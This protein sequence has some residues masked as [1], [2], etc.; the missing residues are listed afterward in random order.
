MN[1]TT[2]P[3][4]IT[5]FQDTDRTWQKSDE[6][7][8]K[9]H[10]AHYTEQTDQKDEAARLPSYVRMCWVMNMASQQGPFMQR[11]KD[12]TTLPHVLTAYDMKI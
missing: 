8:G 6:S 2:R 4:T 3:R 11:L 9:A 7:E 5:N 10:L 1:G 12:I